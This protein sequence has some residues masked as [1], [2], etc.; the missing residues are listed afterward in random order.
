MDQLWR[1]N[2][3]M[4]M[5]DEKQGNPFR[6][7]KNEGI[8]GLWPRSYKKSST[9]QSVMGELL[10]QLGLPKNIKCLEVGAGHNQ[11]PSQSLAQLGARVATLDNDWFETHLDI[12][13]EKLREIEQEMGRGWVIPRIV[14]GKDGVIYCRGDLAFL[15]DPKSF[16]KEEEFDFIYYWGSLQH[17]G[18]CR[19]VQ[20][21]CAS[22]EY[23]IEIE[24]AQ[25]I[26]KP[27]PAVKKGGIMMA[28]AG[29]FAGHETEQVERIVTNNMH[30]AEVGL[31]WAFGSAREAKVLGFFTQSVESIIEK[32]WIESGLKTAEASYENPL[33]RIIQTKSDSLFGKE[34]D[35]ER[36]R[37]AQEWLGAANRERLGKAGIIDAVFVGY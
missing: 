27:I 11:K 6:Y 23:G 30:L 22:K 2:M 12:P 7:F 13:F 4:K 31:Y 36:L 21:S 29:Y 28:V 3:E 19:S 17:N 1:M 10:I 18:I 26:V 5:I 14:G 20:D 33:E 24:Y 15:R 16:L 25:R 35:Y 9:I 8:S 34:K 32:K 37:E